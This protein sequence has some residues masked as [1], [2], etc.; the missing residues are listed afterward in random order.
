MNN[1]RIRRI[2]IPVAGFILFSILV[3]ACANYFYINNSIQK[4]IEDTKK[5]TEYK[6]NLIDETLSENQKGTID[7]QIKTFKDIFDKGLQ[8]IEKLNK[9]IF[10]SNVLTFMISLIAVFLGSI[11]FNNT[12]R[13]T[14]L[15]ER[16]ESAKLQL[17]NERNAMSLYTRIYILLVF[18]ANK[19][20]DRLTRETNELLNEFHNDKY[21]YITHEL[22]SEFD[23]TINKKMLY[24]LEIDKDNDTKNELDIDDSI[25]ALGK[26]QKEISRLRVIDKDENN[27]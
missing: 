5:E 19:D 26:L 18:F 24:Y 21:K 9:R 8:E 23:R 1:K 4:T 17:E 22:K 25:E 27:G 6:I 20:Y 7:C 11:L 2:I 15:V 12:S 13:A 16:T 14:D 10:D 3:V